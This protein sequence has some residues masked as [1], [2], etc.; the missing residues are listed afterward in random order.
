MRRGGERACRRAALGY[1]VQYTAGA[2]L[3]ARATGRSSAW[4][5]VWFGT[6][7]PQVQILSPR[8]DGTKSRF[9]GDFVFRLLFDGDLY[10]PGRFGELPIPDR[11]LGTYDDQVAGFELALLNIDNQPSR[12]NE[13][14]TDSDRELPVQRHPTGAFI[15]LESFQP[16]CDDGADWVRGQ[17]H[18][19]IRH[20]F[21]AREAHYDS[22]PNRPF[23]QQRTAAGA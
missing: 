6:R 21:F 1:D 3:N 2:V 9:S 11:R 7:R 15:W 16:D 22:T 23:R 18:L 4:Q 8:F 17:L 14:E 12:R 5:S 13:H 20:E 10:L 19:Q